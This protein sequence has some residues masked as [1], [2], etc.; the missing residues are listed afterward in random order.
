MNFFRS[1]SATIGAQCFPFGCRCRKTFGFAIDQH[2]R[3]SL[4]V[5]MCLVG[6]FRERL[7]RAPSPSK[8]WQQCATPHQPAFL[9]LQSRQA[10][11]LILLHE[12]YASLGFSN[13]MIIAILRL[14]TSCL[15][16]PPNPKSTR[17]AIFN[18]PASSHDSI[19]SVTSV[20]TTKY[21]SLVQISHVGQP[22]FVQISF[23]S[24]CTSGLLA[25]MLFKL[26]SFRSSSVSNDSSSRVQSHPLSLMS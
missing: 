2:V 18:Q 17:A 14:S 10:V 24:C 19:S 22:T 26:T 13:V 11:I 4:F 20:A 23:D 3:R 9:R 8:S 16:L 25:L 6:G 15:N 7:L 1:P 21:S 5:P 12:M